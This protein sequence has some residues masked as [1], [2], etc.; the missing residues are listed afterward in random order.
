MRENKEKR[1]FLHSTIFVKMCG[2][3]FVIIIVIFSLA[4]GLYSWGVGKIKEQILTDLTVQNTNF[5]NNLITEID[6]IT[7][8]QCELINDWDLK[9]LTLNTSYYT[10]FEKSK[11]MLNVLYRITPIHSS[12][13]LVQE[14]KVI[15][16]SIN[17]YI[18]TKMS[19]EIDEATRKVIEIS[20]ESTHKL[21]TYEQGEFMILI[22]N[23]L[24][25]HKTNQP[26]Q[27]LLQTTLSKRAILYYLKDLNIEEDG[28]VFLL[29]ESHDMLI[30]EE[31][32]ESFNEQIRKA[33]ELKEAERIAQSED[34]ETSLSTHYL[35]Q[36]IQGKP[37]YIVYTNM[38]LQDIRVVKCISERAVFGELRNYNELMIVFIIISVIGVILFAFY[39]RKIIHQPLHALMDSF[40]EVKAGNL[41]IKIEHQHKDEFLYIYDDFNDMIN[42]L[43]DLI[44][45][46]YKQKI[47]IQ[48]S[49]LKQLQAQINPHFLYN[50]FLIL[51]NRIDAGD[52]EFAAEFC[53]QLGIFFR[54]ITKN[55]SSFIFLKD[56]VEHAYTYCKIQYA[57]FSKRM[58]LSLEELPEQY[59][60]F[61]V[62]RLILQ[63]I[64]ENMFL[65]TLEVIDYQGFLKVS[66]QENAP[67]L[68]IVFEDNGNT[69]TEEKLENMRN[70][71]IHNENKEITGLI[72][73]HKRLQLAFNEQCGL[74]FDRSAYGGLKITVRISI[75]LLVEGEE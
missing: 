50:S 75:V 67:Y 10:E 72:N 15:I 17:K 54:F 58:D 29:S 71:L 34:E 26:L 57:R 5:S 9:K 27:F 4:Y 46:Q 25:Y 2:V 41:K 33:I 47:L 35:T 22:A 32:K 60:M 13:K 16:P 37:Y 24:L 51:S 18:G 49:E 59:A 12:S 62:P 69:V 56:E 20:K 52:N 73:I 42:K 43:D 65:Y 63:P 48:K 3:F 8:L 70:L 40:K 31:E 66:F 14:I 38:G 11:M 45:Q 23:P 55:K 21:I 74:S 28:S 30:G 44:N 36:N 39:M 1:E 6:R 64:L 53:R 7:L 61:K 68:D 19:S